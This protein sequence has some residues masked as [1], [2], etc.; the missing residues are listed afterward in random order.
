MKIDPIH[1]VSGVQVTRRPIAQRLPKAERA[2]SGGDA[3]DISQNA[4]V[5]SKALAALREPEPTRSL[6]SDARL[7]GIKNAVGR[8]DYRVDSRVIAERM[9]EYTAASAD[10][11]R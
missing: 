10:G 1:G 7:N 9:L 11:V 2:A 8:G 6:G 3:A 5:F 4:L